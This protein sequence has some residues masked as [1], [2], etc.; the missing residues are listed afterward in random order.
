[1]VIEEYLEGQELSVLAICD[2]YT[3]VPL[4][5][6]QDH[7]RAF[8]GDQVRHYDSYILLLLQNLFTSIRS[9]HCIR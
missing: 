2:G 9:I 6:A 7:K 3:I 1:M 8:D 5:P 4:P